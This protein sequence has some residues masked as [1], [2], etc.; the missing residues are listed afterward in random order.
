MHYSIIINPVAGGHRGAKV[1]PTLKAAL[2]SAQVA[3]TARQTKA[4]DGAFDLAQRIAK[5]HPHATHEAI[6][7]VGGDGTV[8]E[9][10]SGLL[11]AGHHL[12]IGII[13][14]GYQNRFAHQNQLSTTPTTALAQILASPQPTPLPISRF[15]ETIKH[16][17][18]CFLTTF[19]VGLGAAS[20]QQGHRRWGRRLITMLAGLYH[21]APFTLMVQ[22]GRKRQLLPNALLVLAQTASQD[23]TPT[24]I[25][26]EHH[27]WLLSLWTSWLYLR[28]RL[29]RSRWAHHFQG[30][31]IHLTTTSLEFTT[32]DRDPIGNRFLDLT[33]SRA[34]YPCL[35]VS[36]DPEAK[37]TLSSGP[38]IG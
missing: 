15:R 28:G 27:N 4:T 23:S 19:E 29:G 16:E 3:F 10:I 24:V 34:T 14:V 18:S 5:A 11:T 12:P 31:S 21:Q 26:V 6:I 37:K 32:A 8:R 2:E 9:T 35:G 7:I 13:P 22:T 25:V 33:I 17:Q 20:Q 30:S 1:W 38:Q 36:I